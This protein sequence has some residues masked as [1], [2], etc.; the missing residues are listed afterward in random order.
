M[1]DI[2]MDYVPPEAVADKGVT[3]RGLF[4]GIAATLAASALVTAMRPDITR[5]ASIP[6]GRSTSPDHAAGIFHPR[7]DPAHNALPG[8]ESHGKC[9][10]MSARCNCRIMGV[11]SNIYSP[12]P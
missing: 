4:A 10:I 8:Q 7:G 5:S 11:R 3:K 1:T 6:G 12:F 2:N 9:R